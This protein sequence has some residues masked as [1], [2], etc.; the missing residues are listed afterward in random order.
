MHFL[1]SKYI[2]KGKYLKF[3][4]QP[5]IIMTLLSDVTSDVMTFAVLKFSFEK[6]RKGEFDEKPLNDIKWDINL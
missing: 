5:F 6:W 1:G 4:S 2:S 3:I